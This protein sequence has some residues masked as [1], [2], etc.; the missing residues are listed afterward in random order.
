MAAGYQELFL[1][2]G[3]DFNTSITLTDVNGDPYVLTDY[4]AKSQ[5]KKSYYSTHATANFVINISQPT[6]GVIAIS[7]DSANTANISAGRYVYDVIIKNSSNNVT[8]VLEGIVNVLPQ[9]TVF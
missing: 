8:R 7:L 3:S 4:A 5:I 6:D 1:E 2:Q 9:V